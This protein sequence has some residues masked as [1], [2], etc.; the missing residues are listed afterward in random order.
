MVLY[1]TLVGIP[2]GESLPFFVK[3]ACL[4]TAEQM[5]NMCFTVPVQVRTHW[6]AY[7]NILGRQY[8]LYSTFVSQLLHIGSRSLFSI[9]LFSYSC[10]DP[11]SHAKSIGSQ[12]A[13]I[14]VTCKKL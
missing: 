2:T 3:Q 12:T 8:D 4:E 9:Y 11:V 10:S 13:Q 1:V 6:L 7:E 5:V 14:I